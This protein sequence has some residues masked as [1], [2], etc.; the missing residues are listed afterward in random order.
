MLQTVRFFL[1]QLPEIKL[2]KLFKKIAAIFYSNTYYFFYQAIVYQLV[3]FFIQIL[4]TQLH[5]GHW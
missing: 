1:R 4:C 3:G 5:W 2:D